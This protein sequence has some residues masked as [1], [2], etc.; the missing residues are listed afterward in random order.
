MLDK[1]HRDSWTAFLETPNPE[2]NED[3][4]VVRCIE[5]RASTFQGNVPI[6]YIEQLQVVKYFLLIK[7]ELTI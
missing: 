3:H 6:D 5:Q 2:E 1:G 7:Y 4:M